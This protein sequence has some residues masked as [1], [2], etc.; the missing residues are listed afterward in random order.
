SSAASDVYK[1]QAVGTA[2]DVNGDGYAD[3][4]IGTYNYNEVL[5]GQNFGAAWVYY[6]NDG[7]LDV[8]PRQRCADN[9]APIAT[10]GRSDRPDAFRLTLIGRTP[11]GRGRIK[12]EWEVKPLGVLFDGTGIGVS[13]NWMNPGV[14]GAAFNQVI[15]S[16]RPNTPYHWRVRVRYHPGTTPFQQYNRWITVPWNGWNETDLRTAT[17]HRIFLPLVQR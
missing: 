5:Q 12:L 13:P 8:L 11:F 4:V 17:E 9:A 7:G 2:G 16:L 1:R 14:G 3:V 6:G 15:E 10:G